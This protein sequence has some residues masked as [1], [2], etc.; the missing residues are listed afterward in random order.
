[1]LIYVVLRCRTNKE[2]TMLSS[3]GSKIGSHKLVGR[4]SYAY[5]QYAEVKNCPIVY[6]QQDGETGG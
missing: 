4:S 5:Q 6:L 3:H 2:R 1:M